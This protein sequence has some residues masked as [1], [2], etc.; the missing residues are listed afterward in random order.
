[1]DKFGIAS[2]VV[3]FIGVVIWLVGW[4]MYFNEKK[5]KKKKFNSTFFMSVGAIIIVAGIGL[6]L[7]CISK[8]S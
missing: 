6:W 5:N 7:L 2:M 1:M 8:Q 4:V 3:I